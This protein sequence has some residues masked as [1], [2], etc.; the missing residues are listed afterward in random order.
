MTGFRDLE[1]WETLTAA[2]RGVVVIA[3]R[4]PLRFATS[5]AVE[6]A[7]MAVT[8]EATV[9]RAARKLGFDGIKGLKQACAARAGRDEGLAGSIRSR[10]D[11]LE[12][13]EVLS[14]DATARAV[15]AASARILVQLSETLERG[16][17]DEVVGLI[18]SSSRTMVYGLGTGFQ[19][20]DYLSLGL[21]RTG[22]GS[23]TLSGSGHALA[24]DVH[25]LVPDDLLVVFAPRVLLSDIENLID[26]AGSRVA[27]IVLVSQ[28]YPPK[29]VR[30]RV[31]MVELP[32]TAGS[33]ASEVTAAWAISDCLVAELA[34]RNPAAAISARDD[35]QRL[36]DG[37]SPGRIGRSRRR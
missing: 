24:D 31:L 10:L 14:G 34:R 26:V 23:R 21:E 33:A 17:F 8:S 20:A 27:R 35:V 7:G 37:L 32:S 12:D 22:I 18:E 28:V 29:H 6:I 25:R 9:I 4:D 1:G 3:E 19:V 2:E 11:S 16:V 30:D 15:L 13:R 5:T 36:R